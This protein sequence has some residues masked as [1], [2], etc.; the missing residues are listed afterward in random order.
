MLFFFFFFVAAIILSASNLR[1]NNVRNL[2]VRST[3]DARF[4]GFELNAYSKS[5]NSMKFHKFC[6]LQ[7][8]RMYFYKN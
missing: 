6:K 7:L 5:N 3:H 1:S 8:L 2:W 4:P